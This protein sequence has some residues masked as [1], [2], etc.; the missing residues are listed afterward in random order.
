MRWWQWRRLLDSSPAL[1]HL[2][3]LNRKVHIGLARRPG[4][5]NPIIRR[6]RERF[7][8]PIVHCSSSCICVLLR[9][10]LIIITISI[11][12]APMLSQIMTSKIQ[13]IAS[14]TALASVYRVSV[15]IQGHSLVVFVALHLFKALARVTASRLTK[16]PFLRSASTAANGRTGWS[17][18]IIGRRG[19]GRPPDRSQRLLM[20]RLCKVD[21][22]T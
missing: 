4:S 11:T 6:L 2:H 19:R 15:G 8:S 9:I 20:T 7:L 3:L 1:K 14:E 10:L 22:L 17:S 12:P 16:L 5:C 21:A 13:L 18:R